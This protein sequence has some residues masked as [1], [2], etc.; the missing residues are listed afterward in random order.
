MVQVPAPT[1]VTVVD[2]IVQTAEGD[3]MNVTLNPLDDVALTLNVAIPTVLFESA[4]KL[5]LWVAAPTDIVNE[6][7]EDEAEF[8][9]VTRITIG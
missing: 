2:A 3:A 7:V 8:A 6:E 5:M 9:S 1:K 4:A